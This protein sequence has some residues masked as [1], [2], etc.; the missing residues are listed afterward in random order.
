MKILN[1]NGRTE[2]A[3]RR[4]LRLAALLAAIDHPGL[5]R[6]REAGNLDGRVY[7]VMDLIEGRSLAG[8]LDG[9]RLTLDETIRLGIDVAGALGAAHR[10]RLVHG[11]IRP[12]NVLLTADGDARLVDFGVAALSDHRG[13]NRR[14]ASIYRA[15]EQSASPR[16]QV[17]GRADLYGLGAVFY[18]CVVGRPPFVSEGGLVLRRRDTGPPLDPQTAGSDL[19]P[20]LVRIINTLLAWNPDDRYQS[21][22]GLVADLGRL[23]ASAE[24]DFT[25]AHAD[26]AVV[27]PEPPMLGRQDEVATLMRRWREVRA[28]V[29][30]V[31]LIHGPAGSG[32]SRLA[33]QVTAAIRRDGGLVLSGECD[34]DDGVP[35]APLRR[36]IDDHLRAMVDRPVHEYLATI[37]QVRTAAGPAA[38][39]LHG[40]TLTLDDALE[41]SALGE[42]DRHQQVLAALAGFLAGWAKAHGA[43]VLYLDDVQWLDPATR[44]VLRHLTERLKDVP[45]LVLLT[46]R[47]DARSAPALALTRAAVGEARRPDLRLHPLPVD[48]VADLIARTTGG[49]RVDAAT[50]ASLTARSAGNTFTLLQYVDALIDAGLLRPDWGRWQLDGDA[51]KALVTTDDG[52]E[53]ILRRLD[54]LNADSRLVLGVAAVHGSVFDYHL[55]ADAC[56][57]PRHR[58]LDVADTAA[59][60]DLVE[61]RPDGRY[62]FRHD[63]I[64]E[65]LIAQ[66]EPD[67]LREVHQHLAD[68]LAALGGTD[69]ETVFA[70][71]R[72]CAL[73]EPQRD[74]R[75]AVAACAAAGR[76]ALTNHAPAEAVRHLELAEEMAQAGGVPIDAALLTVLATAQL[77]AGHFLFA[78]RTA[79]AGLDRSRD[80]IGRA[81]L[82]RLVAQ[83]K[84]TAWE[85]ETEASTIR[86]ALRELGR[87]PPRRFSLL[88]VT[89]LWT[90]LLGQIIRL[91]RIGYGT[92]RGDAREA[93]RLEASLYA[94]AMRMYGVQLNPV[95]AL[96]YLLRQTY[97]VMRIGPSPELAQWRAGLAFVELVI[98]WRRSG[99]RHA[100]QA[101]ELAREIGDPIL[102]GLMAWMEAF[103][104]HTFGLDQGEAL[105]RVRAEYGQWLELGV[106]SDLN[107][108][109]LWDALHR[110]EV[111]EAQRLAEHRETLI[112]DTGQ[113]QPEARVTFQSPAV[114]RAALAALR[115]WQDRYEDAENLL[116]DRHDRTRLTR[117]ERLPLY[118]AAV[119][120]A[121]HRHDL[122]ET[123]DRAVA[124][125]DGLN[126]P[127][128]VLLPVGYGFYLYRAQGRVEQYRLAS[129]VERGRRHRQAR[130]A[131]R[132]VDKI[133]RT[134]LLRAHL[135]ATRA[136][137]L[138]ADGRAKAALRYLAR[139]EAALATAPAPSVAFE[140]A[141]VRALAFRDLH[142]GTDADQQVQLAL[143]IARE[144]DWPP[145]IDWIAVE[146]DIDEV[147]ARGR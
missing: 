126:L 37:D 147:A 101:V 7:M 72:H 86:A 8:V 18:Q 63:R 33:R 50:A 55:I 54:G 139:N 17:D 11:D 128:R 104:K 38:S 5:A 78:A 111:R 146:F 145:Q 64:R 96:L 124:E 13:A 93:S 24:R 45:L 94:A 92:A 28:G 40:L 10:A 105:L 121:Y 134:P 144:Y 97:P 42:A 84:G 2:A 53:L 103:N 133:V 110:G 85:G 135:V 46:G 95:R 32:K 122:D 88:V 6:V 129:G 35:L 61:R 98:G 100:E 70:L 67:G 52:V 48:V 113:T 91:S 138:Q 41:S 34:P 90:F 79:Q 27:R 116:R 58:V 9:A 77:R 59:W 99:R 115:A 47:D 56:G 73:G 109:L 117:W 107:L 44:Q 123:F 89:T 82:L 69:A 3:E 20:A 102:T 74:P 87:E 21:A 26:R 106:Q 49:L 51:S 125:F 108:I 119:A 131:L 1:Q 75:R 120:V 15:P 16:P 43:A 143:A 130:A 142:A 14:G 140:V 127:V 83:A 80:P 68:A 76:L 31:A 29:G 65:A 22:D 141:R 118:G 12:E 57:L 30:D 39:L 4:F 25:I 81:R 71:A 137:F 132:T 66:Y 62:A 23:A 60:R 136:A 19:P 114:A 112:R 36:A